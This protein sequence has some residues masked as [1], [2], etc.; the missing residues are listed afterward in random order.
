MNKSFLTRLQD[1][2]FT[3]LYKIISHKLLL[4][5]TTTILLCYGV[6]SIEVWK[7]IA[8]AFI[9]A[10]IGVKAFNFA[11]GKINGNNNTTG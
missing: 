6:V 10:N 2:F 5:V 8:L 9:S 1:W 11:R 3:L 7:W 4:M